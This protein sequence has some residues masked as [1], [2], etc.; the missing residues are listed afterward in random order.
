MSAE[1]N[2]STT[3][4]KGRVFNLVQDD[5]TLENGVTIT[6]PPFVVVG[7]KIRVNPTEAKYIERVK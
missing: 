4:H 3:L 7:E 1:I 6:V 5:Y 2:R